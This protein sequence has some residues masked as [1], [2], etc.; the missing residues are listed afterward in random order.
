MRV[1]RSMA[2]RWT[3]IRAAVVVLSVLPGLSGSSAQPLP[4]ALTMSATGGVDLCR[5]GGRC[6]RPE[7]N[8]P[9]FSGDEI[10][11]HLP[12]RIELSVRGQRGSPVAFVALTPNS[13]MRLD[14]GS[15]VPVEIDLR[16]G[17]LILEVAGQPGFDVTFGDLGCRIERGT[18]AIGHNEVDGQPGSSYVANRDAECTCFTEAR[19]THPIARGTV[20]G[21]QRGRPSGV[22]PLTDPFWAN[23]RQQR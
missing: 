3:W 1:V 22:S 18:I 9:I 16:H 11:T 17:L 8:D 6:F 23:L 21:F 10:D 5:L 12:G 14:R 2:T 15:R 19:T 4:D 20:A 7:V 13:R